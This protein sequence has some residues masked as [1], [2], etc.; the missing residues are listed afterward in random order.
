MLLAEA[1]TPPP[2]LASW[3]AC[4]GFIMWMGL[5]AFKYSDRFQGKPSHPPAGELDLRVSAVERG[6]TRIDA[7]VKQLRL[8]IVTNGEKRKADIEKKVDDSHKD[9]KKDLDIQTLRIN[10][11][12]LGVARLCERMRVEMP[13]EGEG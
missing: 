11:T 12:V 4:A 6:V 7:D 5:M 3:L 10:R 2:G 1:L 13:E 9:L 8:D